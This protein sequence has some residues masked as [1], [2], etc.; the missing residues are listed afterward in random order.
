MIYLDY[1][2]TTPLDQQV[3]EAMLPWMTTEYGNASS[4]HSGGR[5]AR[6]AIEEARAEV[7][8]AIGAHPAELVFT[9]GGTEANNSI[10]QSCL[11]ESNLADDVWCSAIEHHS[12]LDLV[13]ARSMKGAQPC[14][15]PVNDEGRVT[16]TALLP[17]NQGRR[18]VSVM[19]VN[20]ET[21]VQQDIRTLRESAPDVL[22]HTDAV[23]AFGKVAFD[24]Q[25][26][27]VD[28]ATISA[29]K[30][31]GPKGVGAM[32]IRRGIDFKATHVGGG[33]ERNRRAG[34]ESV[35]NIVGFQY[36]VR[37]ALA[38]LKQR[39]TVMK[40]C[41]QTLRTLIQQTL[42]D[43]N[44]NTP[45]TG[46]AP[47]ILNISVPNN[48]EIDGEAIVQNLDMRGISV[49]NGSACV[50]GSMQ[51]SHVLVAM[52]RTKSE[53]KAAIR[54]SVGYQSTEKEIRQ[55]VTIISEVIR[56]LCV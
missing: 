25:S 29:H 20:N 12:I 8:A 46:S 36:A 43:V 10:V 22:F 32:F 34:T 11:I 1:S 50:S 56:A 48:G 38:D 17:L 44:I 42:P 15:I 19:H 5:R 45:E 14:V 41:T 51:P 3:L 24:V 37:Y 21:G 47:H 23:Q 28:F 4:V 52:G 39:I 30:L 55:A 49:S 27:G 7:A 9:S 16:T 6:V 53:S 35:A 33:Q 40:Q 26:L 13:V 18:L 2:A 31:H 54:F